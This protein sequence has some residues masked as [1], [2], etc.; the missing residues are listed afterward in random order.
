[1][2][3]KQDRSY[4]P[5]EALAARLSLPIGYLRK[6]AKTRIIPCLDVN[7]R[8]RFLESEV[9]KALSDLAANETGGTSHNPGESGG[10]EK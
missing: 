7:G 9:R 6:L 10:A 5:L 4:L 8:L 3:T 1:M 2:E